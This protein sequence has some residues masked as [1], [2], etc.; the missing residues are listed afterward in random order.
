MYIFFNVDRD[1]VGYKIELSL[2]ERRAR[3]L[4]RPGDPRRASGRLAPLVLPLQVLDGGGD[5][6]V[7]GGGQGVAVDVA[8]LVHGR[9]VIRG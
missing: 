7:V 4:A 3:G 2:Q 9:V 8:R 1:V 5:A 6:E